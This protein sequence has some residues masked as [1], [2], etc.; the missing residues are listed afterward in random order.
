MV[1]EDIIGVIKKM[2]VGRADGVDGIVVEM[3]KSGG[4]TITD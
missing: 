1:R 2:K 3:L 4:I